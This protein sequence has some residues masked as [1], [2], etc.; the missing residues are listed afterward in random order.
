MCVDTK[1]GWKHIIVWFFHKFDTL[2]HMST[3]E[4]RR[5]NDPVINGTIHA[6][7]PTIMI[8]AKRVKNIQIEVHVKSVY[9]KPFKSSLNTFAWSDLKAIIPLTSL[10]D[11][12]INTAH[13][14]KCSTN[15]YG[16]EKMRRYADINFFQQRMGEPC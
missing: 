1:Q 7:G 13:A 10:Q 5:K 9:G 12:N 4:L 16:M 15:I 14:V 8:L 11:K 2:S 6:F 3:Y